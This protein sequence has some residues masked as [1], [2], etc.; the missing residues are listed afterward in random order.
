MDPNRQRTTTAAVVAVLVFLAGTALLVSTVPG[1]MSAQAP[2]EIDSCTTISEPGTYELTADIVNS[3]ADR[4]LFIES[5]GV[6]LEGNGYLVDG[7]DGGDSFGVYV[8]GA[9]GDRITVRDLT[10]RDWEEG[11]RIV[12]GDTV[13][14]DVEA[15]SN[16]DG[17]SAQQ[18]NDGVRFENVDV[19]DNTDD[20]IEAIDVLDLFVIDSR[21]ADNAEDGLYLDNADDGD[22]R[23]NVVV[24]N[25]E[26]GIYGFDTDVMSFGDNVIRN[27]AEDGILVEAQPRQADGGSPDSRAEDMSITD[28]EITDNGDEGIHLRSLG[29]GITVADNT[30]CNSGDKQLLIENVLNIEMS[31]NDADC[32]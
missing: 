14:E 1:V 32:P 19:H 24:N 15:V 2:T 21:S 4:C 13:V 10:V 3:D 18:V 20:G 23:N 31:G 8:D 27:N 5:A 7:V 6:T 9:L 29:R 11:V 26:N 16:F 28:N 30:I 22:V 17:L 25:G 12:D